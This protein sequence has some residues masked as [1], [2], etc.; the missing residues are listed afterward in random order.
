MLAFTNFSF[1]APKENLTVS[2]TANM[3]FI[4]PIVITENS[5]LQFGSLS[6][7]MATNDTITIGTDDSL[8]G[9][10]QLVIS[11]GQSAADLTVTSSST[12]NINILIS[13]IVDGPGYSLSNF[14]CEY[15]SGTPTACGGVG[16]NVSAAPSAPL[17]IGATLTGNGLDTVGVANGSF[18]VVINYQ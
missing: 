7:A 6:I 2:V 16:F 1:S 14:I 18:D 4:D 9:D 13:S 17:K 11:G 15:N 12:A 10:T 8:G 5:A 3:S